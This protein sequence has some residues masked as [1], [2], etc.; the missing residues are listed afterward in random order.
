M[1]AARVVFTFI[2]LAGLA[3]AQEH[4]FFATQDGGRI[5]ADLYGTGD[6]G[7]VLVHGGQFKK[8]SWA[9]QAPVFVKAGFRVAAINLRGVGE[10]TGPK[11]DDQ[12]SAPL[13][14]DVLAAVHYLRQNGAKTVSV[15]GGSMGGSAA[16]DASIVGAPG[17]IDR[18]VL[19][20]AE[21]N[22]PADKLK[23]PLLIIVARDDSNGAGPRLPGIR[24]QF[25]KAPEPKKLIVVEGS[26]HAQ[27]LFETD[28]ADRVMREILAF[29]AAR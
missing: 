20:G 29:L 23:S 16:A 19:L 10:S 5:A 6:R 12:Y 18:L 28:Q 13:H 3:A 24:K 9:K 1:S 8:E 25:D 14:Y 21:P 27:F 2:T 7:L 4:V 22:M 11:Q 26:A 17:E 15:V